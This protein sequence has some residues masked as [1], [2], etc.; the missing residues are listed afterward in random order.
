MARLVVVGAGIIGLSVAWAARRRGH[1]V[2]LL[3]QGPV[4]NPRSASYDQH[5]MIRMHYGRAEGYT[6]M[7]G[8]AFASWDRLWDDLGARH[9][10]DCGAIAVSTRPED[11]AADTLA[12]FRRLGISHEVLGAADTERLCPHLELPGDATGVLAAPGG[13]LYADRILHDLAHHVGAAGVDVHAHTTAQSIDPA[14]ARVTAVGG[15]EF[16]GDLVV[17]ATGAWLPGL[18]PDAYAALPTYRQTLCYVEPPAPRRA[19]WSRAPAIVTL[20]ERNV[21]TLPPLDGAMLK[22]GSGARRRPGRPADGFDEPVETGAGVIDDFAPYLRDAPAYRPL[23]MQVG[24]YVM[25]ASRRFRI[26]RSGQRLVVT[27]CDGQMFKFGPLIAERILAA[28]D[29]EASF[30]DVV[31]WAAG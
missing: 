30:D 27:N 18:M 26:E 16:S 5:R 20:G 23:R 11:C 12:T 25:D 19:A 28:F 3:D 1:S 8:A 24:Y 10:A 6:R 21:Y 29:G 31:R 9:F 14:A 15:R 22:F 7:V 4:P 13:P 2:A 17:V